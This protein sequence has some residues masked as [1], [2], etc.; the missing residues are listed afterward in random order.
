[1]QLEE[2]LARA[3]SV[4]KAGSINDTEIRVPSYSMSGSDGN[5]Q[6]GSADEKWWEAD[7][8]PIPKRDFLWV[9]SLV[10]YLRIISSLT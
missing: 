10:P 9:P 7:E 5:P 2:E 8:I 6:D 4:L 3:N 1:L